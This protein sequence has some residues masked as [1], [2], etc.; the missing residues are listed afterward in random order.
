MDEK[1]TKEGNDNYEDARGIYKRYFRY[2]IGGVIALH[3]G[4]N[5]ADTG[6]S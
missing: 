2:A 5:H 3:A 1:Q 4:N 6:K